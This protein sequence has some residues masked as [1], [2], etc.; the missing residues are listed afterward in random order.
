MILLFPNPDTLRLALTSGAVPVAVSQVPVVAAFA[1]DGRCWVEPTAPLPRA[2]LAELRR[3][4]VEAVRSR[5]VKDTVRLTCWPQLLPLERSP[6]SPVLAGQVPVLFELADP[7]QLPVL[8]GEILRLGNDRQSFRW[9]G[10]EPGSR[11][12][13]RVVG[14]PYYSLLRAL[15]G[16]GPAAPRAY[17]ERAPS[18]WALVGYTHPLLEHVHP[19]QD[20]A[21]LLRPTR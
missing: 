8:V 19:P 4:G 1:D 10:D 2:A 5:E 9:L 16:D 6:D 20:Q 3:L 15:E 17:V 11:V 21:L 12:L 13:L 18:V 7:A 14:P